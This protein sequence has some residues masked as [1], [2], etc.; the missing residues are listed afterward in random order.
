MAH[1]SILNKETDT[2]N[3][4]PL[5]GSKAMTGSLRMGNNRIVNLTDPI[6]DSDAINLQTASILRWSVTGAHTGFIRAT[7]S[8]VVCNFEQTITEEV[9]LS[10]DISQHPPLVLSHLLSASISTIQSWS[11]ASECTGHFIDKDNNLVE[12]AC[13]N[14]IFQLKFPIDFSAGTHILYLHDIIYPS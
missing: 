1:G 13:T 6:L 8:K 7:C 5:D 2:S 11:G 10:G 9:S 14:S 12:F 3:L 4:L